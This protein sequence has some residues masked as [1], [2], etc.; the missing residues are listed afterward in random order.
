M[1]S[2]RPALAWITNDPD[3]IYPDPPWLWRHLARCAAEGVAPIIIA[4]K[5]APQT[6]SLVG[7]L[8]AFAVELHHHYITNTQ[9]DDAEA[10]VERLSWPKVCPVDQVRGHRALEILRTRFL[11]KADA[12]TE[13]AMTDAELERG[14]EMGLTEGDAPQPAL[15]LK[16]AQQTDLPLPPRWIP[17][18]ERWSRWKRYVPPRRAG[19]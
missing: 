14:L 6:F 11:E 4:R 1:A 16:W 17:E 3:W 13:S 7:R 15:L 8:G 10:R 19:P 2:G 18:L 12:N 5:L 9:A